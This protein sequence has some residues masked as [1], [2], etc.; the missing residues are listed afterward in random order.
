MIELVTSRV[1]GGSITSKINV[2]P[3]VSENFQLTAAHC[4][5]I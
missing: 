4:N 3:K 1:F 5:E 2:T